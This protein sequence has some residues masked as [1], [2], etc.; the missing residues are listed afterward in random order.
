MKKIKSNSLTFLIISVVVFTSLISISLSNIFAE[1]LITKVDVIN[2]E[3]IK[4]EVRLELID[5]SSEIIKVY[6]IEDLSKMMKNMELENKKDLNTLEKGSIRIF[7]LIDQEDDNNS[8]RDIIE[9]KIIDF[10]QEDVI[11]GTEFEIYRKKDNKLVKIVK[12]D[13]NGII[14]INLVDGEYYIKQVKGFED[15]IIGDRAIEIKVDRNKNPEGYIIKNKIKTTSISAQQVIRP[16]RNKVSSN[17]VL[18]KNGVEYKSE[19][20]K[21]GQMQ[22][23]WYDL[24]L[25][26][27]IYNEDGSLRIVRNNYTTQE[28]R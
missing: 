2:K 4:G 5:N 17:I 25:Y 22:V 11:Q 18:L 16:S 26:D 1:E 28:V 12:T 13:S 8:E 7:N 3:K 9:E 19:T 10:S 14:D 20:F 21:N 24:P 6:K 23:N 15:I 27:R